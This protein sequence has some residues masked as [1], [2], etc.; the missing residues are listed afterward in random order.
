[1]LTSLKRASFLLR[2]LSILSNKMYTWPV[3][4]VLTVLKEILWLELYD[5]SVQ[6][7]KW[8]LR[9]FLGVRWTR[10]FFGG[11]GE[12]YAAWNQ[13]YF[14][15]ICKVFSADKAIVRTGL[16]EQL[17]VMMNTISFLEWVSWTFSWKTSLRRSSAAARTSCLVSKVPA[18]RGRW[19]L[20]YRTCHPH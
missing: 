3:C 4:G 17:V 13:Q 15:V 9:S 16:G 20:E 12:Q 11:R 6:I 14:E 18:R 10:R 19:R 2:E 8:V 5:A 1:M 7:L